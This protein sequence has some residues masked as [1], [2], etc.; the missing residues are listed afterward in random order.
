MLKTGLFLLMSCGFSVSAAA[1]QFD[2]AAAPSQNLNR[3][4]RVDRANGEVGACQYGLKDGSVGVTIC[5]PA[6]DGAKASTPGD[7]AL[8][9]SHH[10]SEA[11]MFRVNR[12]SGE[13]SICYVLN[14]EQV[15]CTPPAR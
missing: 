14:D 12:R 9:P 1:Q 4:Y 10:L 2:F 7:Y 13:M 3:I 6:G 8:V 15:V 5:Y 11:G